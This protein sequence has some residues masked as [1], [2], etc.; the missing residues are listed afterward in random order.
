MSRRS[1][2]CLMALA[3]VVPASARPV[4][5]ATDPCLS[6]DGKTVAF[7][8]QGDVWTAPVS[9]D[10]PARRLTVHPADDTFPRWSPDGRRIYFA[11]TRNGSMDVYAM[12][13]SGDDIKRITYDSGA[14]YPLCVSPDGS[15]LYGYTTSFGRMDVFRV[16]T[17]GGDVVRLTSHPFEVEY[18][19]SVSPDG[20]KVVYNTGGGPGNWR[21]P[22]HGGSNTARIWI[23]DN[24]V[25][26]R[27]HKMV[28]PGD[29][30]DLFP[31]YIG[32]ETLLFVS[33]RSGAPNLWTVRTDGKG[34]RQIT[35]FT[36][37]TVRLPSADAAGRTAVFQKDSRI[38]KV[39]LNSGAAAP[40]DIEAPADS[41]RDP[42]QD[43][44]LT[45][46][47]REFTV[48]PNGKR[49]VLAVRG[50][51]FLIP[52]RGGTTRRLTTS[53]RYDGQAAWLDDKTVLFAASGDGA[54]RSLQTVTVEGDVKTFLTDEKDLTCPTVSPDR[55]WVA[56]HV[57]DREIRV[58]PSAGGTAKKLAEGDFGGALEGNRAFNWSPD[59]KWLAYRTAKPRGIAIE[60]V[61][62][63][64]GQSVLLAMVGKEASAPVFSGDGKAVAYAAVEGV[65][66]SEV[67]DSKRPLVV[68]D[69]VPQP[70]T[71]SEDDLDKID[72]PKEET[73]KDPSV[74]I[75]E[76][77]LQDRRRVLATGDIGG[78]WSG[79]GRSVYANVDGQ[80]ATVDL[81]TGAVK[82][83]TAVTGAVGSLETA[84][85]RQKVYVVQAGRPSA[86][87]VASGALAPVAFNAQYTVDMAAE[88]SA[89][90]EE[91][92]WAMDRLYYNPAMN[93][94]PW[95]Q[96]R[97]DFKAIV[98]G[99]QSREDFYA[100]MGEMMELLDSSHLGANAPGAG[101]TGGDEAAWLGV[102]WDPVAL[103]TRG[104]YVVKEVYEGTPA[105]NPDSELKPGDRIESV[106]GT[107]LSSATPL[108]TLLNKKAGRK[109]SLSVSR[110][111]RTVSLT[112]QP[113]R[114]SARTGILYRTWVE[115]NRRLV[116][117]YSKGRFGY[118]H[119]QS[120]D[121]PSLDVFL[122][123]I[124]T[125]L[126]GKD[127]VLLD[128]RY[129]GG[130]FTSHII[131]NTMLKSP[132]LIRTVRD[133][134]G[135][136]FSENN[137]R[138]N[139]LELPAACLTN[140]YSFSNAEIFSE[141]FR[142]LKLGP[143]VGETTA[144]GVIGTGAFG[145][146]DGGS[147][148]MPGSGAYAINGEN[149][150]A[151]GRKPDVEVRW[152]PNDSAEDR[153]PQ[154]ETAVKELLKRIPAKG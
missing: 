90:F 79:D 114:P 62:V 70:V 68:V 42:S 43:F 123:E 32:A 142:R 154:L 132:W 112:I 47:A 25:P 14:E 120:M 121:V 33:N 28:L 96:I 41:Q 105:S 103:D 113:V 107:A 81:R 94:K 46:G 36:S 6:P 77:G 76:R 54:K 51:L 134:P 150:E 87:T 119:I 83:V 50:D 49:A 56:F 20:S 21:K 125:E 18:Y 151:N 148:R 57:G 8:W 116:D 16:P 23:A 138:G 44:S 80:L 2:L 35:K 74:R 84:S 118:I 34:L 137:F 7:S 85:N 26:F 124:Q 72:A 136:K 63:E 111:D 131:L 55:K 40:M 89:L 109:T 75:V 13:P 100:L 19:P 48:S 27:N 22:G 88:E 135:V 98:P 61:N 110:N 67:R 58:V 78:L 130:G 66:Y 24:V 73:P 59:G 146:W 64:T 143:V 17:G 93:D 71:Y 38:W 82:P 4:L 53:P 102:E 52:E 15:R 101:R 1:S 133:N 12:A 39:D 95:R 31:T 104:A 147:I 108:S 126:N 30:D 37:G 117:Q 5:R 127:G 149:L 45:T 97:D 60:A 11:S 122:R 3:V 139:A 115:K 145:L 69:L 91:V 141:G 153:D 9:G 92:W 152:N 128:V 140:Q 29:H 10:G 86:L 129:N 106:D 65:N 99:V 144:G